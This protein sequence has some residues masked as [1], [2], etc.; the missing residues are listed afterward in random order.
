[1]PKNNRTFGEMVKTV[2]RAIPRGKT[3]S[4]KEVAI[5]AGNPLAARAVARIMSQNFDGTI[6]CHRV[7]CSNGDLGGYNRGGTEAKRKILQA[8]KITL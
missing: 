3:L 7:I 8:E 6:P 1:M 4:Y 5:K 2:V